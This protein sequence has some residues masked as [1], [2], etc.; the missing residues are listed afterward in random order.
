MVPVLALMHALVSQRDLETA[1][2][3]LNCQIAVAEEQK[4]GLQEKLTT[5]EGYLRAA[6]DSRIQLEAEYEGKLNK[7]EEVHSMQLDLAQQRN[8]DAHKALEDARATV[9][10]LEEQVSTHR[11]EALTLRDELREA[12]LP[13]AAHTEAIDTLTA[14]ITAFREEKTELIL[15]A[16]SIDSRYRTGDLVSCFLKL[17]AQ[18]N[19]SQFPRL[20]ERGRESFHRHSD[21]DL[22]IDSRA[23]AYCQGQRVKTSMFL[24]VAH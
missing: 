24:H 11:Q 6:Q 23:R 18:A 17:I 19:P 9:K 16:R 4:S 12:K 8:E 3:R 5:L 2:G 13:S 15:R 1:V 22:A 7:H 14:Q 10:S 20:I 21:S